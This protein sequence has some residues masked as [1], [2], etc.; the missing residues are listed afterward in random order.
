MPPAYTTQLG[1][2]P[3]RAV[4]PSPGR[5]DAADVAPELGFRFG[6]GLDSRDRVQPGVE[7]ADARADDP[8]QRRHGMVAPLGRHEGELRHATPRAKTAAALRRIR[9]SSSSRFSSRRSR[10]VS[11]SSA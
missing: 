9:F 10:S 5:E 11:A 8:A 1:M 2:D 4:H 6:A 3:G 7:A